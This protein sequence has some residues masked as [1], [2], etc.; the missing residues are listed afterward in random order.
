MARA[1]PLK[2][3]LTFNFHLHSEDKRTDYIYLVLFW[4]LVKEEI[5]TKEKVNVSL[6]K[7]GIYNF[8]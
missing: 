5:E 3:N 8:C 1:K 7:V 2:I 6:Y 4:A